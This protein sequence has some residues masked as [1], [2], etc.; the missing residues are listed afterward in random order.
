MLVLIADDDPETCTLVAAILN[1]AG[2]R[3]MLARDAIQALQLGVQRQPDAIVLDIMMPAGTGVG[4]L[5]KLKQNSR[6][7]EIP[8]VILSGVTDPAKIAKV[9]QLGAA[10]FLPKPVDAEALLSAITAVAP[11]GDGGSAPA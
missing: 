6:T 5:E 4:A 2:H 11:P 10:D 7:A 9:R 1:G 3:T 8:V